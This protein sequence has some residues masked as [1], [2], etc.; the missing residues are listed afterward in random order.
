MW[1]HVDSCG[2]MWYKHVQNTLEETLTYAV[3]LAKPLSKGLE[4]GTN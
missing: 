1:I 2:F 3:Q 4:F